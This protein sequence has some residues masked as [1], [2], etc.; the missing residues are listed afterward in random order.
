MKVNGIIDKLLRLQS[1]FFKLLHQVILKQMKL[2][3]DIA[4]LKIQDLEN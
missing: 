2:K 3:S 4:M 1:L